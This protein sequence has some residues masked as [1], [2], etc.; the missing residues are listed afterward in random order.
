M[1]MGVISLA[2]CGA[3]GVF[4]WSQAPKQISPARASIV[5]SDGTRQRSVPGIFLGIQPKQLPA[6]PAVVPADEPQ[7][8][9]EVSQADA[10]TASVDATPV[11]LET[12]KDSIEPGNSPPAILGANEPLASQTVDTPSPE[13]E[14]ANVNQLYASAGSSLLKPD[15]ATKSRMLNSTVSESATLPRIQA[16]ES[17][18]DSEAA[19]PSIPGSPTGQ[20]RIPC[21]QVHQ[22]I[23]D[24]PDTPAAR[25]AAAALEQFDFRVAR[26]KLFVPSTGKQYE[27]GDSVGRKQFGGRAR[28]PASLASSGA[29]QAP[30]LRELAA[31]M[32]VKD[33]R[34]E[35]KRG[36]TWRWQ[37]RVTRFTD[38]AQKD[39]KVAEKLASIR[40]I[41]GQRTK[42]KNGFGKQEGHDAMTKLAE[43]LGERPAPPLPDVPSP[44]ELMRHHHEMELWGQQ[45]QNAAD[46]R[47]RELMSDTVK[48]K[49][50]AQA[51]YDASVNK[52]LAEIEY[53]S[54]TLYRAAGDVRSEDIIILDP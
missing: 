51:E 31:T 30:G 7:Q 43:A 33:V 24:F 17:L 50:A 5:A 26:G 22:G 23:A 6:T 27:F 39:A 37:I 32:N 44:P 48:L 18:D 54:A 12:P 41:N 38:V 3:A 25:Q 2:I 42:A 52:S 34:V 29:G 53:L 36:A 15:S 8:P 46:Q 40:F 21:L 10:T 47:L 13:I 14:A 4:L 20:T 11:K 9:L 16:L 19:I 49:K 28:L 1:A 45:V 35:L